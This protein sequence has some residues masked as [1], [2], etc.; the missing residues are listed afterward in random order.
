MKSWLTIFLNSVLHRRLFCI[1]SAILLIFSFPLFEFNALAWV[2]LVPL[3]FVLDGQTKI[4]AFR[5][6]YLTGCVFFLG[7]LYWIFCSAP[8]AGFPIIVGVFAVAAIAVYCSL[9]FGLFAVYAAICQRRGLIAKLFLLPSAWVVLEFMR[10]NLFSGFGWVNL[11]YSQYRVLPLIQIA[12][13]TGSAGISFLIVMVNVLIKEALGILGLGTVPKGTAPKQ[14][15]LQGAV[16]LTVG[17]L[18]IVL[19]YGIFQMRKLDSLGTSKVA[20]IQGNIEQ[21]E[22]WVAQEWPDILEKHLLLTKQ[23]AASRPDLVLWPET[24]F[25]GY[26]W[27]SPD[28]YQQVKDSV[29]ENQTPLLLGAVTKEEDKYFNSA[30]LLSGQGLEA[31]QYDK[32]HLV[33]FGEF[34]PL[35]RFLFSFADL[36]PM[37]D[38]TSGTKLTLFPISAVGRDGKKITADFSVLIC[39]EDTISDLAR[40]MTRNG[41]DFLVNISNDAW[42][43]DT[44]EPFLHL[45][46]AVFKAVE[47]RRTLVRVANTGVSGF[48]DVDGGLYRG[49]ENPQGKMTYVAGWTAADVVLTDEMSLYTKF[50]DVFTLFCFGCII[51]ASLK[52]WGQPPSKENS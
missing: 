19:T 25:P 28:V 42:F 52:P 16:I 32:I 22:K 46:A 31:G 45:Q 43:L 51:L 50:G 40:R 24:A 27:E 29:K 6:G 35:R 41:A 13:V 38:F 49:V 23:A 5:Q 17:L 26:L 47:N 44:N 15:E 21:K 34:L 20:V 14:R 2:A 7:T 12:D 48:I 11:G 10:G 33:P 9:Y 18:L 1:F 30:L 3:L 36:I 4:K 37:E 8:S 39:F